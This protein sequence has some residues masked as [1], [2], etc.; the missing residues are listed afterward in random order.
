MKSTTFEQTTDKT[1]CPFMSCPCSGQGKENEVE[2]KDEKDEGKEGAGAYQTIFAVPGQLVV[3][4]SLSTKP[5]SR[6]QIRR[7]N[8][9]DQ[10]KEAMQEKEKTDQEILTRRLRRSRNR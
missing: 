2:I 7:W 10:E 9:A 4:P 5:G 8:E 1:W 6:R 3:P